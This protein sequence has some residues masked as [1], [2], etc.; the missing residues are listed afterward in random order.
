VYIRKFENGK[1]VREDKLGKEDIKVWQCRQYPALCP[2]F[3]AT[4]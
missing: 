1:L 4:V 2:C 3:H